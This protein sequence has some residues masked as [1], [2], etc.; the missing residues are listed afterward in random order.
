MYNKI[1]K[2]S[3]KL[4]IESDDSESDETESDSE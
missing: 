4:N 2:L 3:K 1:Q